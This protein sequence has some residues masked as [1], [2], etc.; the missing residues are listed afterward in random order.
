MGNQQ[1][2][3]VTRAQRICEM[4]FT[5]RDELTLYR[6]SVG[7]KNYK[8]NICPRCFGKLFVNENPDPHPEPH[9]CLGYPVRNVQAQ[10]GPRGVDE[11]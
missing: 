11:L 7:R 5:T 9:L 6:W 4:C 8:N 3:I 1:L 10:E 2:D